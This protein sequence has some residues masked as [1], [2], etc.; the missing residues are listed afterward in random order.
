[1]IG[2][3][4][5]LLARPDEASSVEAR[6]GVHANFWVTSPDAEDATAPPP[7]GERAPTGDGP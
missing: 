3:G 5:A 7:T 2:D 4:S 6:R 1:M